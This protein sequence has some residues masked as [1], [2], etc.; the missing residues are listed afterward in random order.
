ML[1]DSFTRQLKA[2]AEDNCRIVLAFSGGIDSR[3]MLDLLSSFRQR[4]PQYRYLA[5]HI[6]HGLSQEADA[7]QAK[8]KQWTKEA[9]IEFATS[10]VEVHSGSRVSLEQAARDARYHALSQYV[11]AGDLLLTAQHSDDQLE[12]FLLALK[13]GSGPSGLSAMAATRPFY[14][15]TLVR[16]LLAHSRTEIE[17]YASQHKLEWVEDKSNQDQRFDRNFIRHEIAPP[18]VARWPGLRKSVA[19]SALLC[20][21]QELLLSELLADKLTMLMG[22]QGELDVKRLELESERCRNYLLRQWCAL[23]QVLMPSRVQLAEIWNKVACANQ[24]ANPLM[25]IHN[26]QVRRHQHALYLL[27]KHND[28]S[29][30]QASLVDSIEL[31]DHLGVLSFSTKDKTGGSDRGLL[32]RTP[33]AG[34]VVTVKFAIEGLS[35]Q[36]SGRAHSRKLKKLYQEYGVPSW[37]RRRTPLIF[38]G[39]ELAAVADLFVCKSFITDNSELESHLFWNK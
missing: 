34:E 14:Q 32:I 16:P 8:C 5:V 29:Q 27:H 11:S 4:F 23:H 30:W 35:A 36:P 33:Q 28:V 9:G 6:H 38:Y 21:E 22:T 13:R 19:R 18:L 26:Y 12:T 17:T 2:N 24:Q 20:A 15:A 37:A 1:L 25:E 39:E 7:W 3:V 31:P 10:N